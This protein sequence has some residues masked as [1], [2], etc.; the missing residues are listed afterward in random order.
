[1]G[2]LIKSLSTKSLSFIVFIFTTLYSLSIALGSDLLIHVSS[3]LY[4]CSLCGFFIFS[5]MSENL[6]DLSFKQSLVVCF[7][8]FLSLQAG[9]LM[10]L[11]FLPADSSHIWQVDST[12]AHIPISQYYSEFFAGEKPWARIPRR[13]GFITHSITGFIFNLTGSVSTF[14]TYA[15]LVFMKSLVVL[16]LC[17]LGTIVYNVR[18]GLMSA[19]FYIFNPIVL[20]YTTAFYK[21]V[22]VHLLVVVSYLSVLY[23][24]RSRR[25]YF[26]ALAP[27]FIYMLFFERMYLSASFC[28]YPALYLIFSEYN[29]SGK[30]RFLIVSVVVFAG[31]Y[32]LRDY[33]SPSVLLEKIEYHRDRHSQ[34]P[35]V[36]RAMNYD[37]PYF[38]AYIKAALGPYLT[39]SKFSVYK[40]YSLLLVWGAITNHIYQLIFWVYIT[41]ILMTFKKHKTLVFMVVPYVVFLLLMAYIAPWNVR[42]RD[43][44]LPIVGLIFVHA[45]MNKDQI[46]RKIKWKQSIH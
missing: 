12:H 43:S 9:I 30:V 21:E 14:T 39:P 22:G 19:L 1:M 40:G 5:Y 44:F 2:S 24:L 17:F 10:G 25:F 18:L 20:F 11:F 38:V 41:N 34:F 7:S 31:F 32:G 29:L 28:L 46:L 23:P 16:F 37:I 13:S 8:V 35:D 42:V 45:L 33:I 6:K 15:S 26:L 27:I 3:F 36:N 4:V